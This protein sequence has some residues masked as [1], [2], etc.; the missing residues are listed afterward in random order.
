MQSNPMF[1]TEHS[2]KVKAL[3]TGIKADNK[4]N[5]KG[6]CSIH[7][8]RANHNLRDCF[9][10]QQY[11]YDARRKYAYENRRCFN[12]VGMHQARNCTNEDKCTICQGKHVPTG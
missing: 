5:S 11:D 10:F 2:R 3:Q 6:D 7:G 8:D 9:V 4:S 12:C 1:R